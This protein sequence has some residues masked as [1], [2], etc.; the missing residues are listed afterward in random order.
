MPYFVSVI[1]LSVLIT[2]ILT[3]DF[4]SW[5]KL[6]VVFF[7]SLFLYPQNQEPGTDCPSPQLCCY[8]G[9][10]HVKYCFKFGSVKNPLTPRI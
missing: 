10:V 9:S 2:Y 5:V 8:A 1:F 7:W 3:I 6:S 4:N